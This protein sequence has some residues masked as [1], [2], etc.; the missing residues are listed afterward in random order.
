[1]EGNS[2]LKS[3]FLGWWYSEAYL[4]VILFLRKFIVYL[5]DLF[6]VK[7][8][9]KTLFWPWK[10]DQTSYEGLP[11]QERFEILLMN[12]TSRFIGAVIKIFT[13]ITFFLV[14]IVTVVVSSLVLLIWL[15]FPF[16]T[17]FMVAYGLKLSFF[18]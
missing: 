15:I 5:Y 13:I 4:R 1:M 9:L 3:Y 14:L 10:K 17:L 2:E 6:S 11:L 16:L 7:L 8:C 18:S 12:L